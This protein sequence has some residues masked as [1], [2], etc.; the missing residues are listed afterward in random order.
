MIY[1]EP[2]RPFHNWRHCVISL[3]WLSVVG[4]HLVWWIIP[5][6]MQN[7]RSFLSDLPVIN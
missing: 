3:F 2:F 6:F 1:P 4:I 5:L 7:L